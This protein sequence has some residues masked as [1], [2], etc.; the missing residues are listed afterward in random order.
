MT[1]KAAALMLKTAIM[2]QPPD[3]PLPARFQ[4]GNMATLIADSN[5]N[6]SEDDS[7]SN[8]RTNIRLAKTSIPTLIK[9]RD[10]RPQPTQKTPEVINTAMAMSQHTET[11]QKVSLSTMTSDP[12]RYMQGYTPHR[13]GIN[14]T[15]RKPETPQ[16]NTR[17]LPLNPS[18]SAKT[19]AGDG[20]MIHTPNVMRVD[21]RVIQQSSVIRW[22]WQSLSKSI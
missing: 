9:D 13:H 16:Q 5:A 17:I 21:E 7:D 1:Y 12:N 3:A 11:T 2:E 19:R 18:E 10:N 4:I 14:E 8:T 6:D 20:H 15:F 22:P